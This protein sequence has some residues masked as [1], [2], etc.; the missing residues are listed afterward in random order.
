M[1]NSVLTMDRWTDGGTD[2]HSTSA[3]VELRFAAKNE[4]KDLTCNRE[5][6]GRVESK[7]LKL[8]IKKVFI[9]L[10]FPKYVKILAIEQ[11]PTQGFLG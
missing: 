1:R 5:A 2:R 4:M 10:T 3:C 11:Y 6:L 9:I 7:S 8:S